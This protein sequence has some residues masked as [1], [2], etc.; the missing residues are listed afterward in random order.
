MARGHSTR[1]RTAGPRPSTGRATSSTATPSTR[2]SATPTSWS[3]SRSSSWVRGRRARGSTWPEPAT[4]S[5]RRWRRAPQAAGVHLVGRRLRLPLRQPGAHHRRG[6]AP[7]ITRALLLRAEGGV[8]GG[9]RRDHRPARRWRCSSCGPA[10]LP[11]R[12]RPRSPRPCRG[13]N[14]PMR[15]GRC[16]RSLP[17]LKPPFPDPGTPLQLVHHDDVAAAIALAATT[18]A[19]PGAYNLAGDG[20]LSMSD[21]AEALGARPV[22]VPRVAMSAASEVIARLPFVPSALEWLH[23]GTDVGGDGHRQGEVAVGLD[24]ETHCRRDAVGAGGVDL[25]TASDLRCRPG[26][27]GVAPPSSDQSPLAPAALGGVAHDVVVGLLR[28]GSLTL[29]VVGLFLVHRQGLPGDRGFHSGAAATQLVCPVAGHPAAR[30]RNRLVLR[31][32]VRRSEFGTVVVLVGLV[33]P[34]PVLARFERPDDRVSGFP[35]VRGR[36]TRQ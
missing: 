10:S 6:A 23:A 25:V 15:Y 3:T 21:V 19:P 26:R 20:V 9:A 33:V 12:R 22:P 34:E 2:W 27:S 32:A 28:S 24:A 13:T 29:A 4:C 35:P 16:P 14:S 1:R 18:S 7:R 31:P 36:V 11:G 17:L 30:P 8:R 5:R